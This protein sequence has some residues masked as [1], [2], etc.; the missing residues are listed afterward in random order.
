MRNNFSG[1]IV[2]YNSES[3]LDE[4]IDAIGFCSEIILIDLGSSDATLKIAENK[5]VKIIHEKKVEIVEQIREKAC[6]YAKND[7][8]VFMDPDEVFPSLSVTLIDEIISNNKNVGKISLRGENY[9]LGNKIKHGRWRP[10]YFSNRIFNKSNVLFS[11][12]VHSS[13][14]LKDGFK[15]IFV[16]NFKIKHYWVDSYEHFF[17]KHKRYLLFEGER[18]FNRGDRYS[19]FK[20]YILLISKSFDIMFIKKGV[21][22]LKK[23]IILF[24]LAIWYEWRSWQSLKKYQ[25]KVK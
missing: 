12:D 5:K 4:C 1:I 13:I 14:R 10:F 25:E 16:E 23:G 17:E 15:Q 8:I 18:R 20:M 6:S 11:K 19:L 2:T 21:L 24:G 7:W 22:D 9:F 3:H